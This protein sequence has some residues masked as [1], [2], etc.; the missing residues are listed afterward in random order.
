MLVIMAQYLG[1]SDFGKVGSFIS[2]GLIL[3]SIFGFGA[4]T[5]ILPLAA[6]EPASN[7]DVRSLRALNFIGALLCLSA[8]GSIGLLTH[9][10]DFASMVGVSI[11]ADLLI[12]FEQLRLAGQQKHQASSL[13]LLGQRL[14]PLLSVSISLIFWHTFNRAY[15]GSYLLLLVVG[16]IPIVRDRVAGPVKLLLAL[17][18]SKAFWLSSLT[19]N[20]KQLEVLVGA[21]VGG[22]AAAGVLTLGLRI[23]NPVQI[24]PMAAST[25]YVPRMVNLG[26][27]GAQS[28]ENY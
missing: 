5:R 19:V 1:V 14:I 13:V 16:A 18:E 9:E 23:Q 21:M 6:K 12:D 17:K 11:A 26:S 22:P 24:F 4:T 2:I 8:V 15:L 3:S 10:L 20:L 27:D 28:F 25:I 7:Q